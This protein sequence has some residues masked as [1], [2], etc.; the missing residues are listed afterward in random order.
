MTW[1]VLILPYLEQDN[2]YKLWNIQ[3]PYAQQLPA[4]TQNNLKVYFCPSRRSASSSV[5]SSGETP[6]GGLSDYAACSG[7]GDND[8]P[9]ANGAIV[10]ANATITGGVVANWQG[11]VTLVGITDGTSNTFLVGEKHVRY[12]TPFGKSE[13]RSVFSSN[14]NNFRRFAGVGAAGQ[15]YI[16]QLY[17]SAPQW[18]VQAVS[19]RCFGSRHTGVCQFTM[20]DG[21]V[22]TIQ[23]STDVI[24]LSRLAQRNDGQVITGNY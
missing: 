20:C 6:P 14:D 13:D 17:S 19:N 4:A 15:Q 16:L 7:T 11:V 10:G 18:N 9:N 3:L 2:L 22:R 21:S 1:A 12:T 5:F 8:G 23:N 24:T